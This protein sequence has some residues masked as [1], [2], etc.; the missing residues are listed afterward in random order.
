MPDV[1]LA[2]AR[3]AP[4]F[5]IGIDLGGTKVGGV[6]VDPA[7]HPT[8]QVRRSH[9]GSGSG[10]LATA[11]AVAEELAGT[12]PRPGGVGFAVAG[13]V[14]RR[15]NELVQGALIGLSRSPV[16]TLLADRVGLPVVLENDVNATL[17]ALLD[18]EH[19][20]EQVTVVLLALGTGIGGAIAVGRSIVDG[21]SGFA[22]EFGH[23]PIESPGRHRCPCGSSGCLEL[24]ASGTAV[25]RIAQQAGLSPDG[26]AADVVGAAHRG[27]T[28]ALGILDAAGTAIGTALIGLV[29]VLDPA[30]IYLA[31]GFGHAAAPFLIPAIERRL[32]AQRSFPSARPRP[33]VVADPIGPIAAAVGAARLAQQHLTANPV[34]NTERQLP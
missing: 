14:D 9:D 23:I 15:T 3:P 12:H 8:T 33:H 25:G 18:D 27:D 19:L 7:G 4:A 5:A 32:D 34:R 29:N 30:T 22:G 26:N 21:S 6:V 1:V 17:A 10:A 31:G 11:L 24:F 28:S 13:L 16:G 20:D 2:P